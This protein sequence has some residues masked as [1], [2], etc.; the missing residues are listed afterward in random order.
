M[1][2]S[3]NFQQLRTRIIYEYNVLLALQDPRTGLKLGPI[4]ANIP[5]IKDIPGYYD[6]V[7]YPMT[8]GI[9]KEKLLNYVNII[10]WIVDVAFLPFNAKKYY[11]EQSD[12]FRFADIIET[13]LRT[14]MVPRLQNY[15]PN[16]SYPNLEALIQYQQMKNNALQGNNNNSKPDV[17]KQNTNISSSRQNSNNGSVSSNGNTIPLNTETAS[18]QPTEEV[19]YSRA[20]LKAKQNMDKVSQQQIP[21]NHFSNELR[22]SPTATLIAD[23]INSNNLD[24]GRNVATK[25]EIEDF[26]RQNNINTTTLTSK[27]NEIP[28]LNNSQSNTSLISQSSNNTFNSPGQFD[29]SSNSNFSAEPSNFI[30]QQPNIGINPTN[31]SNDSKNNS[32][33]NLQVVKQKKKHVKRGRPPAI[34]FPY[35]Q[36]MRNIVKHVRKSHLPHSKET[37]TAQLEKLPNKADYPG[38]YERIANPVSFEDILKKVKGRKY[39]D[40]N[41]FHDDV[42]LMV[43]NFKMSHSNDVLALSKLE[44]FEMVYKEAAQNE[45][46]RP[47]RDFIPEGEFRYPIEDAVYNN[48]RYK[49]GDWVHILNPNEGAKPIIGQIFKIWKTTSGEI[50]FNACWYFRPEQTVHRADRLFYK[51]EVV[52]SGHYR[53]HRL[54]E[55]TGRCYVVHFTRYQRGDP[56]FEVDEKDEYAPKDQGP[57]YVCEFRYNEN[58]KI[59]N[60][61]RTWRACLPEEIRD[62]EEK[63]KPIAGRR[64][65]KFESPLKKLLPAGATPNDPIPEAKMGDENAPPLV[66]AVYLGPVYAKDDLGEFATS[67]DCPR[68]IIRPGESFEDGEVDEKHGTLTV[69]LSNAANQAAFNQPKPINPRDLPAGVQLSTHNSRHSAS[70]NVGSTSSFKTLKKDHKIRKSTLGSPTTSVQSLSQMVS[71]Y[72]NN[73]NNT[74][75]NQNAVLMGKNILAR[76]IPLS[77]AISSRGISGK[78][79]N[80][81][82]G[83]RNV[84]GNNGN[85]SGLGT[86]FANNNINIPG[87]NGLLSST[88]IVST[89]IKST[90]KPGRVVVDSPNAFMFPMSIKGQN[91][92][93]RTDDINVIN[94]DI[95]KCIQRADKA[96]QRRRLNKEELRQRRSNQYGEV[97]W[98]KGSSLNVSE[99]LVNLGDSNL[100]SSP[101]RTYQSILQMLKDIDRLK[102]IDYKEIEEEVLGP[103]SNGLMSTMNP[104]NFNAIPGPPLLDPMEHIQENPHIIDTMTP[105]GLRPSSSYMAYKLS[106]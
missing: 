7:K 59:F 34:D 81:E 82:I 23:T 67:L 35:V 73:N 78:I 30:I 98:F 92:I 9:L 87:S 5:P 49:I 84:L 91:G 71:D 77:K 13:H 66:G 18:P 33:V 88:G 32:N 100:D 60:K 28:Q 46:A 16:V 48:I 3:T 20:M 24:K 17:I 14:V 89:G 45:L 1:S 25:K 21:F 54:E 38:Y 83:L 52:K 41:S 2:D 42:M 104:T 12:Y 55:I 40:F 74:N 10:Q 43:S 99:R 15:Y 58:D 79:N 4:F 93:I 26:M 6:V 63:T 76:N 51:N 27:N 68:Y 105:N 80:K 85:M 69:D 53:D 11:G 44:L 86:G 47:D 37:V 103:D 70:K 106:K 29:E 95:D 36:R 96:S 94:S 22:N 50:W 62:I 56:I 64:F 102:N 75:I 8:F 101:F 57:L 19:K 61:I 90:T 31:F 39:K 72:D 65:F 97:I